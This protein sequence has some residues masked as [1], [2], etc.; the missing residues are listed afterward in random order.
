[1]RLEGKP[2]A[3]VEVRF[4]PTAVNLGAEYVAKGVTD[5]QGHFTLTCNGQSGA[6]ACDNRVLVMEAEL[7]G[8]LKSENAQVELKAY[9]DKLGGRPLP[10]RYQNLADSPLV[11]N[12]T[13]EQKSYAFELKR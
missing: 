10:P 12:V 6:C 3:K 1:M 8:R 4:I 9:F 13:T 11:A 2:L 7:P 5:E